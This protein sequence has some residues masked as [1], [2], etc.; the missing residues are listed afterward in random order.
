[1]LRKSHNHIMFALPCRGHAHCD[2]HSRTTLAGWRIIRPTC[3]EPVGIMQR[4]RKMSRYLC[5][6]NKNVTTLLKNKATERFN[7]TTTSLSV[8]WTTND[9]LMHQLISPR[10]SKV[11]CYIRLA[12]AHKDGLGEAVSRPRSNVNISIPEVSSLL[13]I[14]SLVCCLK[15]RYPR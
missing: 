7:V 3:D 15:D 5:K 11:G 9:A 4:W 10:K 14:C 12:E 8:R 13:R 1:M 6:T 2:K